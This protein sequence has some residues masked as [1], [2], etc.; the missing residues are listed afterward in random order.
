MVQNRQKKIAARS[1]AAGVSSARPS[2]VNSS[3]KAMTT[4]PSN[5][6][7]NTNDEMHQKVRDGRER[8]NLSVGPEVKKAVENLAIL[9]GMT[10]SQLV[11]HALIGAMPSLHQQAA[12]V[13]QLRALE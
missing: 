3:N 9:L 2:G 6:G 8:I 4:P 12:T 10:E 13:S 11:V 1:G 5:T 7:G